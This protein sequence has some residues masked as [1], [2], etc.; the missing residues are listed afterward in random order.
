MTAPVF[1]VSSQ[2]AR[3][4]Q[5]GGQVR[6]DGPEG[7]HAV[8]VRRLGVGE[9]IDLTDGFGVLMRCVVVEVSGRDELRA[10]VKAIVRQ[11]RPVPWLTVVQALP[12]GDAGELAVT[13]LTEVGVDEIVP[14]S[15]ARSVARWDAKAVRG[16][17]KWRIAAIAAGKQARRPRLPIIADLA[18]TR[19]VVARVATTPLAIVLH[20]EPLPSALAGDLAQQLEP[21][22]G[23]PISSEI[24]LIVGPE[25][26]LTDHELAAFL[27]A[28][29]RALRLGPTVM[30]AA[31]AGA[32][33]AAAL[34]SRTARWERGDA[35]G[36]SASDSGTGRIAL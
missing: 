4:V 21:A 14:W 24:L 23:A 15:A 20:E 1:L 17:E 5:V 32:F 3:T 22:S 2:I 26:G 30:R 8:A 33:A 36:A 16:A 9:R 7:R 34:L 11:A 13:L 31:T 28:G 35:P 27:E 18:D 10:E 25:G 19:A 6:L 12:K 29:A